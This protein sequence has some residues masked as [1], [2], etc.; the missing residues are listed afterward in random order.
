[1]TDRLRQRAVECRPAGNH[2]LWC[3]ATV[4]LMVGHVDSDESNGAQEN[5]GPTCRSCNAKVGHVM[6][7]HGMGR[8]TRQ[9]N[10]RSTQGAQTLAQW[11]AAVMSMKGEPDQMS[12]S[13]AVEMIHST[14]ASDRSHFAR[15]I[16]RLRREH[17][18][19]QNDTVLFKGESVICLSS[20]PFDHFTRSSALVFDNA[21]CEENRNYIR[22]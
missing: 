7:R 9:Y 5:L 8:R 11:M 10:P 1:M 17:G 4:R 15:E 22:S 16:W 6:K 20:S 13:D 14:P 2:C 3:G 12:V 18:T 21:L 19:G